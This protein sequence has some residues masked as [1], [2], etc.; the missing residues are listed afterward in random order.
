LATWIDNVVYVNQLFLV[1][2]NKYQY[3]SF[4]LYFT[5]MFYLVG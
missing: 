4:T 2:Y 5:I 1:I 3:K